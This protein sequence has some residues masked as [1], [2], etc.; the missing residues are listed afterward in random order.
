M[1]KVLLSTIY[2]SYSIIASANRFSVDRIILLVDKRPDDIMKESIKLIEASLGSVLKVEKVSTE[3][4]DIVGIAKQLVDLID[5]IPEKDDVFVDVTSGRKPKS[6]ALL[7]AAYARSKHIK[8]IVYVTE[9]T[10]Q[11]IT[12]P[13][14]AYT[15]NTTQTHCLEIK[16]ASM[17]VTNVQIAQKLGYTKAIIYR[18]TRELLE[19]DAIEKVG[20]ELRLT[21]FGEILLL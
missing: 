13:K 20:E 16:K 19:I 12:L 21:D 7:F 3:I 11:I 4:Y 18:N 6:L 15:L 17:A 9:D 2:N 10:K 14:M 8:K 1:T 5:S